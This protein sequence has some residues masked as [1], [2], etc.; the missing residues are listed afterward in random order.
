ML[1]TVLISE[2][3]VECVA[4]PI[5]Q[6]SFKP[7]C[8]VTG[9]QITGEKSHSQHSNSKSTALMCCGILL[10]IQFQTQT[11]TVYTD[12]HLLPSPH[13][14]TFIRTRTSIKGRTQQNCC[15]ISCLKLAS[16]GEENGRG[17]KD[18][19]RREKRKTS[20]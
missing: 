11:P 9:D 5:N 10:T 18:C 6:A 13:Q 17:S 4:H 15:S 14:F 8:L 12:A 19:L 1:H 3:H 2:V 7:A 20:Q 16:K